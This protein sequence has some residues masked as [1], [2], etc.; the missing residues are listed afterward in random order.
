MAAKDYSYD[1]L[2]EDMPE[3]VLF[4]ENRN[5]KALREERRNFD[6]MLVDLSKKRKTLQ[7]EKMRSLFHGYVDERI[8]E[9]ETK[10]F[11]I[12]KI[13]KQKRSSATGRLIPGRSEA[14]IT[15][16]PVS[17]ENNENVTHTNTNENNDNSSLMHEKCQA[18]E[19]NDNSKEEMHVHENKVKLNKAT[20]KSPVIA[21]ES[22]S[23]SERL[24][25]ASFR[26]VPYKKVAYPYKTKYNR[27]SSCNKI[28]DNP[29]VI[30]KNFPPLQNRFS[31]IEDIVE[32]SNIRPSDSEYTDCDDTEDQ[33]PQLN[34]NNKNRHTK[35]KN[36]QN[37]T[38]K[39]KLSNLQQIEKIMED[40]SK[41]TQSGKEKEPNTANERRPKSPPPIHIEDSRVIWSDLM[42]KLTDSGIENYDANCVDEKI[43]LNPSDENTY[44][45]IVSLLTEQ[46]IFYYTYS[47][48]ADRPIKV[49]IKKL[50]N[51]TRP[52]AI[53]E[54]LL[55]RGFSVESVI[56]FKKRKEGELVNIP[57]YLV[58]LARNEMSKNIYNITR[59]QRMVVRIEEYRGRNTPIMCFRCQK[60]GHTQLACKLPPKCVKCGNDHESRDCTIVT[61]E[62]SSN[63]KCAN[64]AQNHVASSRECPYYIKHTQK[65]AKQLPNESKYTAYA[66]RIFEGKSYATAAKAT[67]NTIDT[68]QTLT[69]KLAMLTQKADEA[70]TRLSGMLNKLESSQL[71]ELLSSLKPFLRN[72]ED[73]SENKK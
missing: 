47:L 4:I 55:D 54:E 3:L 42:Q 21:N 30:Y 35:H 33:C 64:C 52:E 27:S 40:G 49:I 1:K 2:M 38:R 53:R 62:D 67:I 60:I 46:K 51:T 5:L 19:T 39:R 32:E 28:N 37:V 73:T 16:K 11:N 25:I 6:N 48:P 23:D 29:E 50:P 65:I 41:E 59:L 66:T 9:K 71:V 43:T 24:S 58:S 31:P 63:I 7:V 15:E 26:S 17:K 12:E 10:I 70:I 8:K 36:K 57:T 13:G 18:E 61:P 34:N 56:Q 45:K 14:G 22:D 69:E 72:I 68:A 44:R 20:Q